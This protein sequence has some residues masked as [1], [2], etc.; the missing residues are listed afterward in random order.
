MNNDRESFKTWENSRTEKSPGDGRSLEDYLNIFDIT[1]DEL[2]NATV[3]DLGSGP[4]ELGTETHTLNY[5]PGDGFTEFKVDNCKV[6][7]VNPEYAHNRYLRLNARE[8]KHTDDND[9]SVAAIGQ[10]LPFRENFFKFIFAVASVSR[11]CEPGKYGGVASAWVKEGFRV[12]Q[13]DGKF[14]IA[15]AYDPLRDENYESYVKDMED[16]KD[17][18]LRVGF[19]TV[20]LDKKILK[21][22]DNK[23]LRIIAIK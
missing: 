21:G 10:E 7:A 20:T 5:T 4:L 19:R 11:Y 22:Q 23:E 16:I 13:S 3:L 2:N 12:L 6:I 8:Y 9:S 15:H 1:P 18:L 17:L 14:C